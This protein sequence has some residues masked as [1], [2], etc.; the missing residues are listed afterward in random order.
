MPS[1][2]ANKEE[3]GGKVTDETSHAELSEGGG[4]DFS[5]VSVEDEKN[6]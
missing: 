3:S 5:S 1:K 4:S 6:K 2:C